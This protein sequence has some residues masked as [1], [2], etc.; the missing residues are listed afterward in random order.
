MSFLETVDLAS[1][2]MNEEDSVSEKEPLRVLDPVFAD[3]PGDD[4]LTNEKKSTAAST[5]SPPKHL[6]SSPSASSST[7]SLQS[8]EANRQR[9][10]SFLAPIDI[11]VSTADQGLRGIGNSLENSYKFLFGKMERQGEDMPKTL[12]DAKKLVNSPS[13]VP[14]PVKPG[15]ISAIDGALK[16]AGSENSVQS[17]M[18]GNSS[19]RD[20]S[21]ER[22]P[23][24][25]PLSKAATMPVAGAVAMGE[26]MKNFS[27]QISRFAGMGVMRGFSKS[28]V[29]T[30][31]AN[32]IAATGTGVGGAKGLGIT[33]EESEKGHSRKES[34]PVADL[35][36][37]RASLRLL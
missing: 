18:P 6:G 2:N 31:S 3:H 28:A 22:T 25:T 14:D 1:L 10:P 8:P 11:A 12:E 29:S 36:S 16:R 9:K 5:L 4:Y 13:L 35:L 26:S 34:A 30:T 15:I 21:R 37:V 20:R 33:S 23:S 27:S 32:P 19:Q 24:P 17:L 7:T